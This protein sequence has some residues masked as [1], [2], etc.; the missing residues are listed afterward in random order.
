LF[1]YGRYLLIASS[2]PGTL[3]ANLQGK[4]NDSNVPAWRSDYHID[5]NLQMNYWP[6]D[7]ANLSECFEPLPRW[8]DSIRAVR[9]EDTKESFGTRGWAMRA[10]NGLFGGS[11]WNWIWGGSAWI[12]QNVWDHYEFNGDEQYLRELAYPMMKEVCEFWLDSV[13]EL[14]DGT[15]VSP[16]GYS[17]EHG[18]TKG[19]SSERGASMDQQLMWDLFS[20]TI[21]ASPFRHRKFSASTKPSVKS[22]R[23]SAA[24][25][26]VRKLE[27]GDSFRNGWR[28]LTILRIPTAMYP[29]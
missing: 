1:Q 21:Q 2:R 26:W 29:T 13:Q 27:A 11:T 4:W 18:P 28:I 24:V 22:C 19:R 5:V 6:A 25:C 12:M 17:P 23:I 7:L 8:L 16:S 9:K 14:P 20:N 3:P 10:E 15:L